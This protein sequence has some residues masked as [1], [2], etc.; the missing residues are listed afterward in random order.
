[1]GYIADIIYRWFT[2]SERFFSSL[3]IPLRIARS[4]YGKEACQHL[5]CSAIVYEINIVLLRN[6][7]YLRVR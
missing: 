3:R 1:M 5:N 7:N 4:E 6:T 2:I